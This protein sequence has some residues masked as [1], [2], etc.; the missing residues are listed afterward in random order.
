VQGDFGRAE[1]P[2]GN[3]AGP[4]SA[5]RVSRHSGFGPRAGEKARG[6]GSISHERKPAGQAKLAAVGVPA[7]HERVAERGRLRGH[8]RAV[9]EQD[10]CRSGRDA[11]A[12]AGEVVRP[13]KPRVVDAAQEKAVTPA[14]D[15]R[16][17]VQEN[18][19]AGIFIDGNPAKKIVVSENAEPRPG[20]LRDEPF[21][22]CPRG[23]SALSDV[24]VVVP[25][26]NDGIACHAPG[27]AFD[28]IHQ[29]GIEIAVEI[30]DLE[31]PEPFERWREAA[32]GDAVFRET[33]IQEIPASECPETRSAQ[34]SGD[35]GIF[36][37]EEAEQSRRGFPAQE[38][39]L[40]FEAA[41]EDAGPE[42]QGQA[43]PVF[44]LEPL[45]DH[46][47]RVIRVRRLR[48]LSCRSGRGACPR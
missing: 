5:R 15:H 19:Q 3:P 4:G 27:R 1:K 40:A 35:H 26:Q 48:H 10:R 12:G 28:G 13:E 29:R 36:A 14:L 43:L 25:G 33:D 21:H 16:I 8:L 9:R 6:D 23:V 34:A 30:A 32:Q 38:Q 24:V 20:K 18:P 11:A 47:E 2:G 31:Q 42:P 17:F 44:I 22:Q 41:R 37:A 46:G 7:E 39:A 45:I